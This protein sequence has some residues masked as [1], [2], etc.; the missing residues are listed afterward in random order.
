[1]KSAKPIV[2]EKQEFEN[3]DIAKKNSIFDPSDYHNSDARIKIHDFSINYTCLSTDL[4]VEP[5]MEEFK[6]IVYEFENRDF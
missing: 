5:L 6:L 3:R 4:S 1:M 2:I